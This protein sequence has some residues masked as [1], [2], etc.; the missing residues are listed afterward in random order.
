MILRIYYLNVKCDYVE[1]GCFLRF[2]TTN[3]K[4]NLDI[5]LDYREQFDFR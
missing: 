1:L 2:S 3:D 4:L 5:K